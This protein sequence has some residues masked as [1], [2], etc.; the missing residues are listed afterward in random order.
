VLLTKY[1]SADQ[2]KKNDMGGTCGTYGRQKRCI[3]GSGG[4]LEEKRPLGMREEY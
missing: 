3:Q 4:G 2:I 1:Y